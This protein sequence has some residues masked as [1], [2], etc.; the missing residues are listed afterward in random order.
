MSLLSRA[1][2][3]RFFF[4][5]RY[6]YVLLFTKSRAHFEIEIVFLIN[7]ARAIHLSECRRNE[8]Q[9]LNRRAA[10]IRAHIRAQALDRRLRRRVNTGN[11]FES[12][13]LR[14]QIESLELRVTEAHRP[15]DR[16]IGRRTRYGHVHRRR[17]ALER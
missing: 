12:P 16:G 6:D 4:L 3:V 9:I 5:L 10:R 15:G 13:H 11:A 17:A 14:R 1:P 8:L 7:R 2:F